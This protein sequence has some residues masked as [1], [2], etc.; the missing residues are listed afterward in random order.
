M[1]THDELI[2]EN[3]GYIKKLL[4]KV[5]TCP[6]SLGQEDVEK[7]VHNI[8]IFYEKKAYW[9][10]TL[11]RLEKL[12]KHKEL[13]EYTKLGKEYGTNKDRE[14]KA[15]LSKSVT[16]LDFEINQASYMVDCF[17]GLI[18]QTEIACQMYRTHQAS[19]RSQLTTYSSLG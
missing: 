18:I 4:K 3:E 19:N 5:N 13:Q 10:K 17:K 2:N 11:T 14:V 9:Q 6:I 1:K 16:E 8:F 7:V 12:Q 15:K